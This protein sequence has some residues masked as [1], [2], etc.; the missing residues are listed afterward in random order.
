MADVLAEAV[1]ELAADAD[2]FGSDYQKA[3][4]GL[5]KDANSSAKQV[6][7]AFAQLSGDL[8]KEFEKATREIEREFKKQERAAEAHARRLEIVAARNA[9][10]MERDA[11]RAQR[12]VERETIRAQREIERETLRVQREIEKETK[13]VA[14]ENEKAQEQYKKEFIASQQ[15]MEKAA[16]E[17]SERQAAS[18]R[19]NLDTVRRFASER[20]SLT[21]GVDTSQLAGAVGSLTKL[22][23]LLGALG[24]GAV[25]GQASLAGVAQLVLAVQQLV[26]ALAL[27]PAAGAAAGIVVGT[28][29]LGLRGL[30]DAIKADSPKELE[31][32]FK[33]LSENGKKVATVI[34]D[35]KDDFLELTKSIQQKLLDGFNVEIER[36]AKALLPRLANGFGDVAKEINL[37]ARA[38]TAFVRERQTLNDIDKVF[39]NTAKSVQVFRGALRP[40]AEALRDVIAIGSDFL[41]QIALDVGATTARISQLIKQARESGALAEFFENAIKAVKDFIGVLSNIGGIFGAIS[42]AAETSLGGGFLTV[43]RTA[44]QS[45]ETFVK[46]ARGQTALIQF[47]ESAQEAAKVILPVLGDLA[48]LILEVVLPAFLKLG[49]VAAPGLAALVD[50]LRRGLE[51]AIPGIIS[52]VD[53]LAGVVE[54]LVDA[55]VLDALGELVR[56]LGTSL[57]SAILSVAPTLGKLVSSVLA[58]LAEI[59]PK[60]LPGLV[61]F[62]NAM[63]DLVIAA[64][65]VVDVLAEIVST[66][67][68]PTLAKIAET[69]TPIIG[70]LAKSLG[71]VLLP[72]LPDLAAAFGE[73]VDAAGPL[74]DDVLVL[75]ISLLR[76]IVPFLPAIVRGGAMIAEAFSKLTGAVSGIIEPISKFIEK[77]LAIPGVAKFFKEDLPLIIA[78]LGG[79]LVIALLKIIELLG[80][81]FTK[82]DE[83]GVFDAIILGF[84]GFMLAMQQAGAVLEWLG[85]TVGSVFDFMNRTAGAAMTAIGEDI[86]SAW[87]GIKNFFIGIW[88]VIKSIF[89]AAW[90][91]ITAI[92]SGGARILLAIITGNFNAIPGI[93]SDSLRRMRD[94]AGDAFNALVEFVRSIPGRIVSALGN[95]GSLLYSA[96]QDVV[97]G[98]INGITS[99]ASGIGRAAGEAAAGALR[100]ARD[101]IISKSPSKAMMWVGQDFGKGFIIGIED[102]MKQVNVAGATLA[103]GA[104][105]TTTGA[106]ATPDNASTF[107]MNETLNRLT[108]NGLGQPPTSTGPSTATAVETAP[109]VVS[110]EIHVYVGDEELTSFVS[111][112]VDERDRRTKRSLN[113]GARR[114]V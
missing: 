79:G 78:M 92:V 4:K 12:E 43:L 7:K 113:M 100:A 111:D 101:A 103:R 105:E 33:K 21:L 104:L 19:K 27:L 31:E 14:R 22:G 47:F 90:N 56:V 64:L 50:G 68:L 69:L 109:I 15:A 52:F 65:P 54:T 51:T 98:M 91:I 72:I 34:R 106:L 46:S 18:I 28:L 41:P 24:T 29:T 49:T 99:M 75:L 114:T 5:E 86:Q 45:V 87:E 3:L 58:K 97:R 17:S 11:I 81:L 70:E 74:V 84:T 62:A 30:G 36:L 59:I 85:S 83:A 40:A 77:M 38:L 112:V 89:M 20:F 80:F 88:E 9:A 71:D 60:I 73:W 57:G 63:G 13:R 10:A 8:G 48:R 6:D 26:G 2:K 67:G 25:I 39:F 95:M 94:A 82:L 32:S 107:R 37:S 42:D 44:T 76:I 61:K 110:P 102:M 66:V 53:S 108:S 16:R 23:G 35:L 55:G 1:V 93:V 96:G